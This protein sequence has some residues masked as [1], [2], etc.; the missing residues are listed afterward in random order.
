MIN[1]YLYTYI[2]IIVKYYDIIYLFYSILLYFIIF[3]MSIFILIFFL[4]EEIKKKNNIMIM[5]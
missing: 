4:Y 2:Y 1:K 3:N 5:I